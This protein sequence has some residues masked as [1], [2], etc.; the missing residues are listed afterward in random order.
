PTPPGSPLGAPA[1]ARGPAPARTRRPVVSR[2]S[3]TGT[4][5]GNTKA[6]IADATKSLTSPKTAAQGPGSA[7]APGSD[8]ALSV[9]PAR[10]A[11][12]GALSVSPGWVPLPRTRR[13]SP[14]TPAS[15]PPS[16]STSATPPRPRHRQ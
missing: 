7:G 10:P 11:P 8:P 4:P 5:A 2:P 9:T 16:P 14:S 12:A 1:G 6:L 13:P 15:S 3:L